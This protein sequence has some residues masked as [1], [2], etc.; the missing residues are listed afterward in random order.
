[1]SRQ[2]ILLK[3]TSIVLLF[4]L[5]MLGCKTKDDVKIRRPNV[6]FILIDDLSHLGVSAYGSNMISSNHGLFEKARVHTKNI[7]RLAKQGVMCRYAYAYPLCEPTRIALMTGKRNHRNFLHPKAQHESDITFGDVFKRAGYATGIFGKWKQ[8]RGTNEVRG[9][10]YIYKF[11]WDEFACFDVVSEGQR[12]INP[13]LVINGEVV[14][15]QGRSDID[16]HTGRRWYGPDIINRH[17]LDFIDRNKDRPFFLYYPMLLVHDEH[18]PTPDTR[19]KTL[20]DGFDEATHNKNGRAGDDPA[21]LP[22]MITYMDKLIGKVVSTIEE[23]KLSEHSLI[24]IMADNGTKEIFSHILPDGT[25]YPGRKGGTSDN[26]TRVPLIFHLPSA[27]GNDRGE[28]VVQHDGLVDVVD[29]FPTICQAAGVGVPNQNFLDGQSIWPALTRRNGEGRKHI[30]TWYNRNETYSSDSLLLEYAFT[31]KFKYYAPTAKFPRGRFFDI[32]T[33]KF[34]TT[35]DRFEIR[36]W[37]LRLYSGLPID[38]LNDEQREAY[39][40]LKQVI[41]QNKY[42]PVADIEIKEKITELG[43]GHVFQLSFNLLPKEATRNS[44]IWYSENKDIIK[45]NKFGEIKG[46]RKGKTKIHLYAWDDALPVA[47]NRNPTF[48]KQGLHDVIEIEIK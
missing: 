12:F 11:G 27:L 35:G 41:N 19:P 1:M 15:Y 5:I 26:G 39:E 29:I 37:G 23:H 48:F 20:F 43:L 8:S 31:K 40:Y 9:K 38:S 28:V 32:E 46:L 44:V 16:P 17:A 47:N 42:V 21:Y 3:L 13:N 10:D 45:V 2:G 14:N 25:T 6:V 7:D 36:K 30:Y 33:D 22:D 4:A 18:K 24:V 34:E